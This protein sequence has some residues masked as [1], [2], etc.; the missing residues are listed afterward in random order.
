MRVLMFSWEFP[1]HVVGGL[2][3][4]VAELVP[5][6]GG[7]M[8]A[9]GPLYL[10][11]VTP[12][13]NGGAWIE[14]VSEY[15]TVHRVDVPPIDPQDN[16]NSIVSN[17]IPLADHA[18]HLASR[19]PYDVVHVHDW[20]VTKAGITLKERWKVPMVTTMHATERGRHRGHTPD[21]ASYRIDRTE[22]LSCFEAWRVIA[23]SQFMNHELHE[24]FELP[25]SKVAIIPNGVHADRP[26]L[27]TPEAAE[28]FR[29][30]HAPNEERLLV[31]VGRIVYEKGL[32]ILLR[33]MPR[34]VADYP[35]TKLLV[36]GK[37]GAVYYPLAYE[38]GVENSV[39]F[40]DYVSDHDRDCLYSVADAAIFPS[41]YEPFGIVALEAMSAGCNVIASSVGG[42]AEIVHHLQNGLT[43]YPNDPM[44]IVWAV[45]QLFNDPEA[46]ARRRETALSEAHTIYSWK[47]IAEQT[48]ELYD[49][50]INDR[51]GTEW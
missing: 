34:I 35:H 33:A 15:V 31:F 47:R 12:R 22:W 17:N 23:C 25:Y 48:A 1:P 40:L 27:C 8:T 19:T 41:L 10:D 14:D 24:Y 43:V 3:K 51:R 9:D 4:H 38:L 29:K 44:S 13:C 50:V 18:M 36:A 32:Q 7:Q 49:Q 6:L 28:E 5:A 16:Y 20:L 2:G 11:L 26:R 39:V 37:N 21:E 45:D 30:R 42:L 46:A